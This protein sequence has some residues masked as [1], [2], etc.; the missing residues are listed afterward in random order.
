MISALIHIKQTKKKT[1]KLRRSE[2]AGLKRFIF[3]PQYSLIYITDRPSLSLFHSRYIVHL[4]LDAHIHNPRSLPIAFSFNLFLFWLRLIFL[5]DRSYKSAFL[6][7]NFPNNY[8]ISIKTVY[9]GKIWVIYFLNISIERA[10]WIGNGDLDPYCPTSF[11]H[12]DLE[13]RHGAAVS[14]G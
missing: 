7:Y 6:S 13:V 14:G 4:F 10:A 3:I 12:S 5:S 11:W 8:L 2:F 9:L 1:L